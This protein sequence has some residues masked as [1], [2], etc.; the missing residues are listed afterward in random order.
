MRSL[1]TGGSGYFGSVLVRRLLALGHTVRVLDIIDAADRPDGVEFMQGDIRDYTPVASACEGMDWVFHNVAQV[2]LAKSRNLFESVNV[3]GTRNL[4]RAAMERGVAKVV[5][6]S[7]SAV[8][9]VP[10]ELPVL[11]TTPPTPA[12]AYGRAKLAAE[13]LCREYADMGLDVSIV[14]PRTILGHGRLGIF[15]IL[16]DWVRRGSAIPVLNQG[17]NVYQFVHASDLADACCLAAAVRG[18]EDFN[19]GAVEFGT[20]FETLQALIQ[21][22]ATGST[23]RSVPMILAENA[24]RV[25]STLGLSPLGPYHAL[26]YGRSMFFDSSKAGR[27]IGYKPKFSNVDMMIDSFQAYVR[28]PSMKGGSAHRSEVRKRILALAPWVLLGFPRAQPAARPLNR[29]PKR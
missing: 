14:R 27:L 7:S 1:V 13:V 24:M 22:A 6:T 8:Y 29:V 5:Y 28:E 17:Q 10:L 12:E 2:P 15:Q 16:F 26:M 20:L 18:S 23:L 4:C 19:I 9:G 3:G 21:H 25:T 11:E